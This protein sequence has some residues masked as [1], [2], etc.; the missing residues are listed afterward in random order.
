MKEGGNRF[1]KSMNVCFNER[2][3]GSG[4]VSEQT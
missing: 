1:P 2:Q 4:S 3:F